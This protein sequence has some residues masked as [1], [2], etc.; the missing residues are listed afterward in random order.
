[1]TELKTI[2][3][4]IDCNV[5]ESV[6]ELLDKY[7]RPNPLYFPEKTYTDLTPN[8]SYNVVTW[9]GME[10]LKDYIRQG[11]EE[12]TGVK[13]TPLYVQCWVNILTTGQQITPH[14]HVNQDFSKEDFVS[15][16][17]HVKINESSFNYY[18]NEKEP[19][20]NKKGQITVFSPRL[21]HYTDPVVDDE[22]ISVAFDIITEK[23]FN[24]YSDLINW[25]KI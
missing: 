13:G 20:M 25:V 24:Q 18:G 7:G 19:V 22:R 6:Q 4:G 16:H 5:I 11:Y 9:P 1:M 8:Y 17:L 3:T 21:S 14:T 12:F 15:G 23:L 10:S 2:D